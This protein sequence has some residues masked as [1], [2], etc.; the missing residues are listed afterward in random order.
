MS[1]KLLDWLIRP[2]TKEESK[3]FWDSIL[4]TLPN[5]TRVKKGSR[6]HL[7]YIEDRLDLLMKD[8]PHAEEKE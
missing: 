4:I 6:D 1:K 3:N 2:M 7:N 5:G 8:R